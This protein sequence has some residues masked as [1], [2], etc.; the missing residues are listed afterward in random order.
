[1]KKIMILLVMLG[2]FATTAE[3]EL[4]AYEGFDYD[5]SSS[6]SLD[7]RNGGI[8]WNGAWQTSSASLARP[9]ESLDSDAFPFTP[10]GTRLKDTNGGNGYRILQSGSTIAMDEVGVDYM[11]V[12]VKKNSGGYFQIEGRRSSDN[13]RKFRFGVGSDS[14]VFIEIDNTKA[15]ASSALTLGTTY[16]MVV[17]ISHAETSDTAYLKVY[18][19]GDTVDTSDPTSWTVQTTDNTGIVIDKIYWQF[20]NISIEADEF[21]IGTT[22]ADVAAPEPATLALLGTGLLTLLKRRK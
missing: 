11:S 14:K 19:P 9:A 20:Q 16:F 17:K 2:L 10:V 13:L 8:G 1:M 12:L 5:V 18:A 21:R 7:G 22:W 4:L 3:A 15:T 6:T